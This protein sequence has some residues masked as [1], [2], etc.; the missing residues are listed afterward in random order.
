MILCP[1]RNCLQTGIL[2]KSDYF[3]Y[4]QP[5]PDL[6]E[7]LAFFV[8]NS[9]AFFID[10]VIEPTKEQEDIS[11]FYT[12]L[13][14]AQ[15]TGSSFICS[16]KAFPALHASIKSVVLL[17]GVFVEVGVQM[18]VFSFFVSDSRSLP[19]LLEQRAQVHTLRVEVVISDGL[20]LVMEDRD[21][22]RNHLPVFKYRAREPTIGSIKSLST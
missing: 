1:F 12:S 11:W 18:D 19:N 8:I 21:R 14:V 5:A 4:L 7:P 2:I 20:F 9:L 15:Y 13:F 10:N 16:K 22:Q 3:I 17:N 6:M